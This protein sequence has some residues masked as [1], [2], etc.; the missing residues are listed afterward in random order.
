MA[1]DVIDI[2]A[3][4]L[5]VAMA[6]VVAYVMFCYR[7]LLAAQTE[8]ARR[9]VALECSN[10][11]PTDPS[12]SREKREP[13]V[14]NPAV[15]KLPA[16]L[17]SRDVL[18]R[19]VDG[20]N[21]DRRREPDVEHG[22]ALVGRIDGDGGS[23]QIIING[24]IDAG[25]EVQKSGGHV[26]FDR[27][28]QQ[29]EL[30]QLQLM[31]ARASHI[32]DAHL[33]PGTLDRCSSGDLRTDRGNVLAS[34]TREMVFC[35]ATVASRHAWSAAQDPTSIC[36]EGLKLDFYYLGYAS[37]FEYRKVLP[38]TADDEPALWAPPAMLGLL[39]RGLQRT[40]LD[41]TNLCSLPQFC[42]RLCEIA[43]DASRKPCLELCHRTEG[44]KA[45]ILV[46]DAS[47]PPQVMVE[48]HGTMSQFRPEFLA[49]H[50]TPHIWFTEIALAVAQEM[51][52]AVC[53][54]QL[55]PDEPLMAQ[56]SGDRK[57]AAES[58]GVGVAVNERS[59]P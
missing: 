49:K 19:L 29:R 17:I 20:I 53:S 25:H 1:R 6:G 38:H 51:A 36:L 22:F 14:A 39:R 41:W 8:I 3:I 10:R 59:I 26:K 37:G 52:A 15:E 24:L 23:R 47:G 28:Y 58:G 30:Q 32:G 31:D 48:R 45:L 42:V 27:D 55:T 7:E 46:G 43:I 33:H 44:W 34:R 16:V 11:R 13:L 18:G 35:I 9:L 12:D 4:V 57:F 40:R 2:L 56:V 21:Q 50:W 5:V 54:Q